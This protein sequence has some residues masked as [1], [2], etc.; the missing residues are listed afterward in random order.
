MKKSG[1]KFLENFT[2]LLFHL[3]SAKQAVSVGSSTIVHAVV[4]P[5]PDDDIHTAACLVKRYCESVTLATDKSERFR[6]VIISTININRYEIGLCHFLRNDNGTL[7]TAVFIGRYSR[8]SA[9]RFNRS[10]RNVY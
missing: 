9:C 1:V 4:F 5:C 6:Q 8:D 3:L 10:C 2:P 7:D